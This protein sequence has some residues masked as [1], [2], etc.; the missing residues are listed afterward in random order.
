MLVLVL[1]A[2]TSA[3]K[4]MLYDDVRGVIKVVSH[5]FPH[6]EA[7]IGVHDASG[8]YEAVIRAGREAAGGND[9]AAI[10]C[11]GVWHS[12]VAC[13]ADMR[14]ASK[15]YLWNF[16]GTET[17]CRKIRSDSEK[18]RSIY[19]RTGCVPNIT[20]QPYTILYLKRNGFKTEDKFFTS[21]GALIFF[22]LTGERAETKCMASG[23]GLLNERELVY[24]DKIMELCGVRPDQF[25][26]LT[27]YE[28]T[29]PLLM[30]PAEALGIPSGIPVVP[31]HSDGALNQVGNGCVL[32]GRM[33]LSVG[34][35]AAIRMSCE[36]PLMS[37]PPATWC[38]TGVTGWM[39]GGLQTAHAIA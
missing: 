16:T 25:G 36:L 34:T 30:E 38:Y 29:A 15:A 17:I 20:Y 18:S 22:N 24:D 32:P 39:A 37:D 4:A 7:A 10:A 27:D 6:N 8:I 35:S 33:T 26:K 21:Q 31:A 13:D 5:D 12:I 19:R 11:G 28:D 1:E 9:V 3:A 2:S 14:P 23:M